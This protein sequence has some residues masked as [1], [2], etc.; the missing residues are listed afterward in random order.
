MVVC[1]TFYIF[2]YHQKRDIMNYYI[3][4]NG[5]LLFTVTPTEMLDMDKE[6]L[7]PV[8]LLEESGALGNGFHDCTDMIGLTSAPAICDDLDDEG[9]PSDTANVWYYAD[10]NTCLEKEVLLN[11]GYVVY[12]AHEDNEVGAVEYPSNVLDAI[13]FT[14]AMF[15]K[16]LSFCGGKMMFQN[17][18]YSGQISSVIRDGQINLDLG[19]QAMVNCLQ[20][21]MQVGYWGV[22]VLEYN[23]DNQLIEL[24]VILNSYDG[25][26]PKGEVRTA[27][28]GNRHINNL[29]ILETPDCN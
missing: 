4:P 7:F 3:L 10:Y 2:E 29:I 21:Y 25:E 22:K 1:L 26:R 15:W 23:P 16:N 19:F 6:V 13:F 11:Q 18:V 5:N 17:G 20:G 27:I 28:N 8:D 24:D 9:Y 12:T 14:K